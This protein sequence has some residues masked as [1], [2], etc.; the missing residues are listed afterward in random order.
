MTAVGVD[1]VCRP[2]EA[3]GAVPHPP[4]SR[5]D[6]EVL[7]QWDVV[8]A[9]VCGECLRGGPDAGPAAPCPTRAPFDLVRTKARRVLAVQRSLAV[10]WLVPAGVKVCG[11]AAFPGG[12]TS[13]ALVL[14]H[15]ESAWM[16]RRLGAG[17]A[18]LFARFEADG[19]L[20]APCPVHIA[21][22]QV[23]DGFAALR[24]VAGTLG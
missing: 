24:A 4:L 3:A 17:H 18:P 10:G 21:Y 22:R 23:W 14:R 7:D 20:A 9:H 8:S 1:R 12:E 13:T 5:Q 2:L 6:M 16:L 11:E 19:L 15:S